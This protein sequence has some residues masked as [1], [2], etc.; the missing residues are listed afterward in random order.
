MLKTCFADSTGL[1]TQAEGQST[2][3]IYYSGDLTFAAKFDPSLRIHF[4]VE[5]GRAT[6]VT[7]EQRGTKHDG[8]RVP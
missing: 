3:P 6:R 4:D 1:L 2:F 8:P 7:V 5:N